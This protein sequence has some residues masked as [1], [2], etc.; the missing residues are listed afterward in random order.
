MNEANPTRQI[1]LLTRRVSAL[2]EII[3][4]MMKMAASQNPDLLPEMEERLSFIADDFAGD[5]FDEEAATVETVLGDFIGR[6]S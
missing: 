2:Q 1:A 6:P 5:G 4:E 3:V